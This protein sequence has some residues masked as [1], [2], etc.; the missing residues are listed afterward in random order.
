MA[1]ITNL[2]AANA[3][4]FE[5]GSTA[6][7]TSGSNTTLSVVTGQSP[8]D[9]GT[10]SM[11]ATATAAGQVELIS[12]RWT[13]SAA[14]E[15]VC[16]SQLRTSTTTAG[17]TATALI[18]WY[19]AA[20]GG[21]SLGT[22]SFTVNVNTSSGWF[23]A[24]YP[25]VIGVAPANAL[26]ATLKLTVT[27]LAAAEY[28]NFD[29]INAS[30]TTKRAGQL[31]DYNTQSIE[32]STAGWLA[33]N[34]TMTRVSGALETNAG[35]AVLG[36]T[37]VAAGNVD[38]STN[39]YAAVTGG[40]TY[41]AYAAVQALWS[42]T[43]YAELRWYDASN[44]LLS[45]EQRTEAYTTPSVLRLAIVGRAPTDA[46]KAKIYIRP[47]ATAAG[48]LFYVD[49]VYLCPAPNPVGNLLTYDEFSTESTLPAWTLTGGTGLGRIF[50]TSG[51]TD[52]YY[53]L[54]Y[55][56]TDHGIQTLSL[57]RLIPVTPGTTYVVGA[58]YFGYN[59][60]AEATTQTYR[61]RIDWYDAGGLLFQA[62]NPDGFYS[63]TVQ[64]GT[65]SG[66]SS[67]ETRK[68]PEGAALARVTVEIDHSGSLLSAY[69]VDNVIFKE[70]TPEYELNVD[71]ETGAIIFTM[72]ATPP[73]GTGGTITVQRVHQDGTM[74][75]LR[76]YG[77]EYDRA[78]FTE[79]PLVIEDYE[80][81]LGQSVW[82]KADW[83]DVAGTRSWMENTQ[84]VNTPK[85]DDS[86]YVW[87]K[88]PGLPAVNTR[89]MMEAPLK[90]ARASRSAT[91]EIV[92]RKN[93]V[94]VTDRRGGRTSSLTILVWDASANELFNSL[95]DSG[96]PA[97][98]QA[99]PGYGIDGNL[100][101]SVGDVSVEPLDPDAREE[102]WR[103]TLAVAEIDRPSGG[104]QGSAGATWQTILD[105]YDTWEDLFNS[106]ETW[107]DVLTKG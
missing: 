107:A 32:Q 95:L 58:T 26:S 97:L 83:Y 14:Q 2:L 29:N 91:Y 33:G 37:S 42:T 80:A 36:V 18:T 31:F 102:G 79:T 46:V 61:A 88:S 73:Y 50:L 57:D 98:I 85:L 20:T 70:S 54:T 25:V 5:G 106:H 27:G 105:A 103:W 53:S 72:N 59:P 74:V 104:I 90:W 22:A 38:I 48:Q 34:G 12:P 6:W 76:G 77:L 86:N 9:G 69:Y 1:Y 44:A 30:P 4:T 8:S 101:L 23:V 62:D 94:N 47:Q 68:C 15:Y 99:M 67:T 35:F 75:P 39:A 89:V 17:K 19:D 84:T 28:V 81:P 96:L 3:S 16:R 65:I 10:Y 63:R 78:P 55:T 87:F 82:Y 40:A 60:S 66:S 45:T 49:D 13:V 71:N 51:I 93:P 92:G 24:N 43:V 100:Y 21:T 64:P 11:R 52:G 7:V 56:P 41:V